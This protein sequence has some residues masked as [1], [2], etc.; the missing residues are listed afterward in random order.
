MVKELAL[1]ALKAFI[2]SCPAVARVLLIANKIGDENSTQDKSSIM[3]ELTS[4]GLLIQD[5]RGSILFDISSII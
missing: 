4:G 1:D 2:N 3:G 5:T